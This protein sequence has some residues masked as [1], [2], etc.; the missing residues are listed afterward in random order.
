MVILL[1]AY[2]FTGYAVNSILGCAIYCA[3]GLL[4]GLTLMKKSFMYV[5]GSVGEMVTAKFKR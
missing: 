4:L 3:L 2:M 1:A 5:V